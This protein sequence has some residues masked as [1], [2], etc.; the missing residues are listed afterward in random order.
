MRRRLFASVV[1][2]AVVVS[3]LGIVQPWSWCPTD[4]R[5]ATRVDVQG[6]FADVTVEGTVYR[7]GA[8]ALLDYMPRGFTSPFDLWLYETFHAERHGLGINAS[9]SAISRDALG[10]PEV[11][12]F[13]AVRGN[14]VWSR[15]PTTYQVQTAADGYP[16]GA[17]SPVPNE[18]WRQAQA[19]DGPAWP[20]GE[21]IRLE[22]WVD[23][24]GHPY[25][26]AIPPFALMRGG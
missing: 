8:S 13:R 7:V 2:V 20:D 18:A 22:V 11:T 1:I 15:R 10:T 23:I 17:A 6:S 12:C 16:P 9:I 21:T 26:F 4:W 3:A 25:I 24:R 5:N 14:E 19:N